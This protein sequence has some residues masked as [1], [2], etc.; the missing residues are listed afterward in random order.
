MPKTIPC[1]A[2]KKKISLEAAACPKCGHPLT[3]EDRA[4]AL[5]NARRGPIGCLAF[6]AI[7]ILIA[8]FSG[9]EDDKSP[10][11]PTTQS[12][13]SSTLKTESIKTFDYGLNTFVSRFNRFAAEVGAHGLTGSFTKESGKVKDTAKLMYSDAVGMVLTFDKQHGKIAEIT[14]V[15]GKASPS[16]AVD[17]I[18]C[19]GGII[20]ITCPSLDS[21]GRGQILRDLGIITDAGAHLPE[22]GS[23]IRGNVKFWVMTSKELGFWFGA[24]PQ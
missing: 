18:I 4:T 6:I 7:V 20:A 3:D 14:M 12:T 22:K 1:P 21:K 17:P 10:Q 13:S 24:T 8:M 23:A 9:G 5:K 16:Q 2:C 15:S 19:M 11:Q